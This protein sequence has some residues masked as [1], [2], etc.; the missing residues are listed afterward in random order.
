MRKFIIIL[1][2]TV[3]LTSVILWLGCAAGPVDVTKKPG[4]LYGTGIGESLNEQMAL[5]NAKHQ[6]RLDIASQVETTIAQSIEETDTGSRV[7]TKQTS[8]AILRGCEVVKEE[9]K[10]EGDL[11]RA[12]AE[13]RMPVKEKPVTGS[14][15]KP[16]PGSAGV[17]GSRTQTEPRE[18]AVE[19]GK[20]K[21]IQ[22]IGVGKSKNMKFAI[23]MAK[24]EARRDIA[25]QSG[26]TL[27]N[28]TVVKEEVKQ[29][30]DICRAYV[31]MRMPVGEKPVV[32]RREP[33]LKPKQVPKHS[34]SEISKHSYSAGGYW[35][36][37]R[38]YWQTG[39]PA[40]SIVAIHIPPEADRNDWI[41]EGKYAAYTGSEEWRWTIESAEPS[42]EEVSNKER[43]TFAVTLK[44]E[45]AHPR[46]KDRWRPY[47]YINP[48]YL[49]LL[50]ASA[51]ETI[52]TSI[53]VIE[54]YKVRPKKSGMQTGST[55]IPLGPLR[56]QGV[57]EV[58]AWY[59]MRTGVLVKEEAKT[60][61]GEI[62]ESI[63][64]ETNIK[65]R[66][67]EK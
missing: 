67:L 59:D 41:A 21:Y 58:F 33:T 53:G 52:N 13:M 19:S 29:E 62:L 7:F 22:G 16:T 38:L 60:D 66:V 34:Y 45:P 3:F 65:L 31:E 26:G 40:S 1:L 10:Q 15:R 64:K 46:L 11:Y 50:E 30:G 8:S 25:S 4:Y 39:Q 43:F 35:Q 48:K 36:A 23:D 57:R 9:V 32:R 63:I 6:A 18:T 5:E 49:K 54:C 28:C 27:A 14:R 17:A 44:F 24:S 55:P 47:P 20:S 61:K 42:K 56:A 37:V 51:T 2:L 12:Y